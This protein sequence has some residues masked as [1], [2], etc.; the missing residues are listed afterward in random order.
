VITGETLAEEEAIT[1]LVARGV[2]N[3]VDAEE[4]VDVTDMAWLKA[5]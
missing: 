3:V 1:L 5:E 4:A 2:E